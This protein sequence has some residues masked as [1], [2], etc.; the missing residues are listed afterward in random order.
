[1]PSPLLTLFLFTHSAT[2][3]IYPLSLHALFRSRGGSFY[4]HRHLD[5]NARS[6]AP[7]GK[8]LGRR[9]SWP[10]GRQLSHPRRP[11]GRRHEVPDP[12]SEEHTSELQSRSD[13][14]CRLLLEKK[15]VLTRD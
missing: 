10:H 3:A 6:C 15:K 9:I 4:R 5:V 2:P 11:R 14:V 1:D 13:L 8:A 12:R 7:R